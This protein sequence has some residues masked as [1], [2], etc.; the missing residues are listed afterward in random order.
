MKLLALETSTEACSAALAVDGDVR[1]RY[2]IAPRRHAELILPMVD[3]LLKDAGV[4]LTDLDAFAFGRGPGAFTGVRIAAGVIQGLAFGADR[5][6]IPV[7]TLAALAQG[8]VAEANAI[9]AA[10]DARM[11]EIYWGT[12]TVGNDGLVVA[13]G[14]ER[15]CKADSV[16][17]PNAAEW[18]GVG[19]GWATYGEILSGKL[20][21][22]LRGLA[23]DRFPRAQDVLKL[24]TRELEAG[25]AV[26]AAEALPVY[27]RHPVQHGT[28]SE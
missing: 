27:L 4:R 11:G 19:T 20:G 1:E 14:E 10:I 7:S 16:E 13:A 9:A 22:R 21:S 5:A 18:F 8:A 23:G 25:R 3:G 28:N 26:T 2:E 12:F 15:V 24:A 6:V 17:V